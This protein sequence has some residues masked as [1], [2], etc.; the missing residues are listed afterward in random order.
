MR[1][2]LKE[3]AQTLALR[4]LTGS[5]R[6]VPR[7]LSPSS[8]PLSVSFSG[9]PFPA[10]ARARPVLFLA[11]TTSALFAAATLLVHGGP[12]PAF[13]FF[14]RRAAFFVTLFDMLCFSF[15]FA[16]IFRF[17]PTCHNSSLSEQF[18]AR[19]VCGF[20]AHFPPYAQRPRMERTFY[21]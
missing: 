13:C 18:G 4:V 7:K 9:H 12:S 2:L 19:H 11:A 16:G 21:K 3:R 1:S 8:N 6:G 10:L 15:L 17:A 20:T 5:I 14:L